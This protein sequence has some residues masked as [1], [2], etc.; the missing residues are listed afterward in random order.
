[1]NW[2]AMALTI[3]ALDADPEAADPPGIKRDDD[4]KKLMASLG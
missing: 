1:M 4:E 3:S 2:G